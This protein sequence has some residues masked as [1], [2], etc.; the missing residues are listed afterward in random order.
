VIIKQV[1]TN[2]LVSF[3]SQLTD[4]SGSIPRD[5]GPPF[6][7]VYWRDLE[8]NYIARRA[9]CRVYYRTYSSGNYF[10]LSHAG[11]V[12]SRVAIGWAKSRGPL[13]AGAPSE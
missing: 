3:G 13:S 1:C 8:T 11:T 10:Y 2:G 7:A 4:Y 6:I 12:V 5:D 9:E